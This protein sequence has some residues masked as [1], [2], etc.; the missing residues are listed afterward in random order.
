MKKLLMLVISAAVLVAASA[1]GA[2]AGEVKGPPGTPCGG[3]NQPACA[4]NGNTNRTGAPEHS[5]SACSFSGLNDMN[6]NNGPTQNRTQTPANQGAPGDPGHGVPGFP[7]G[8]RGGSNP[9][10]PPS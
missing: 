8:C 9:E 5:N 10:N 2:F 6:P 7:N 1:S 4:E 3:P